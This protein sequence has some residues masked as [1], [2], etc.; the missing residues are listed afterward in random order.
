MKNVSKVEKYDELMSTIFAC[1]NAFKQ[2]CDDEI[3]SI[4]IDS[5][6]DLRVDSIMNNKEVNIEFLRGGIRFEVDRTFLGVIKNKLRSSKTQLK[7][8]VVIYN[9]CIIVDP[10]SRF[11][12][13]KIEPINK[14]SGT[15]TILPEEDYDMPSAEDLFGNHSLNESKQ[16][17]RLSPLNES[18]LMNNLNE[19]YEVFNTGDDKE[20]DRYKYQEELNNILKNKGRLAFK[21]TDIFKRNQD[22]CLNIGYDNYGVDLRDPDS[23][24]WDC[25]Y[26]DIKKH[27]ILLEADEFG[28]LCLELYNFKKKRNNY[29]ELYAWKFEVNTLKIIIKFIKSLKKQDLIESRKYARYVDEVISEGG[30]LE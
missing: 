23:H 15:H 13:I 5:Y 14:F 8:K 22:L 12:D 30:E 16:F 10:K 2:A 26:Y 4:Y 3:G 18:V 17:N 27:V 19:S 25:K 28:D 9:D 29:S 24:F 20:E 11:T 7:R 21:A 6:V 1:V